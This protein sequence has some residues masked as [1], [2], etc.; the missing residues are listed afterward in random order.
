[1]H[2]YDVRPR[3]DRRGFDLISEHLPFGAAVVCRGCG[4]HQL[5][6]VLLALAFGNHSLFDESG[7]VIETHEHAGEIGRSG[8]TLCW[9]WRTMIACWGLPVSGFETLDEQSP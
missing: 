6:E 4:P 8:I 3:K 2:I 7:A 9:S 1:M 5:R